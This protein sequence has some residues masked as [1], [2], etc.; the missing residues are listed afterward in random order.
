M[1]RDN[2]YDAVCNASNLVAALNK[3]TKLGQSDLEEA[4]KSGRPFVVENAKY[5]C[6]MCLGEIELTPNST[7]RYLDEQSPQDLT[8]KS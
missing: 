5:T 4:F 8:P 2:N 6:V 7:I 3:E 1:H